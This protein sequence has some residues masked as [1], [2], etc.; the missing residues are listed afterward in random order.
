MMPSV[1][2]EPPHPEY[3]DAVAFE[4]LPTLSADQHPLRTQSGVR[5]YTSI[6]RYE[7]SQRPALQLHLTV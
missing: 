1:F 5:L 6:S 3:V 7:Y 2:N 4:V